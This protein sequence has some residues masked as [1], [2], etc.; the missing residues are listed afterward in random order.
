MKERTI[1]NCVNAI[2]LTVIMMAVVFVRMVCTGEPISA[3]FIGIVTVV[4]FISAYVLVS[5][6]EKMDAF[7]KKHKVLYA[8]LQAF[9][10]TMLFCTVRVLNGK[11]QM[12]TACIAGGIIFVILTVINYTCICRKVSKKNN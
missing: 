1:Q 9:F 8:G 7:G 4:I 6:S 11:M 3:V 10:V 5:S 12:K 2:F